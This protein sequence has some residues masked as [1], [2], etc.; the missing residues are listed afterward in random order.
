MVFSLRSTSARVVIISLTNRPLP[1]L[2]SRHSVRNGAFVI[3]AM[4]ARTTGGCA[5]WGPIESE[6]FSVE[7]TVDVGV[8]ITPLWRTAPDARTEDRVAVIS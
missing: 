3:P 4:G 6:E 7:S 8:G 5:L 1:P 2:N